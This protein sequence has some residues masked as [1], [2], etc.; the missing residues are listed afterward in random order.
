[1]L[2]TLR[3][4]RVNTDTKGTC[5]FVRIIR[6]SVFSGLFLERKFEIFQCRETIHYIRVSVVSGCP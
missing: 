3:A 2:I 5:L 1:M 6:V 4:S